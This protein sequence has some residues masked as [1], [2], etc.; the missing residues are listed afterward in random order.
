MPYYDTLSE[1]PCM[2]VVVFTQIK[3][4]PF[5]L[6]YFWTYIH[7][8]LFTHL[9]RY[10]IIELKLVL[11]HGNPHFTPTFYFFPHSLS[12]YFLLFFLFTSTLIYHFPHTP[13]LR[14]QFRKKQHK[15]LSFGTS[16][17][18]LCHSHHPTCMLV[19]SF[20]FLGRPFSVFVFGLLV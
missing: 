7:I 1:T 11:G 6:F 9:I 15:G 17:V 16:L 5:L 13:F 12:L 4:F 14:C 3:S 19:S 18:C 10:E 20:L 8:F 2:L